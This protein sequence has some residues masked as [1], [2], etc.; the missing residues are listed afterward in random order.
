MSDFLL[1]LEEYTPTIPDAVI[2][3][4]LATSGFDTSDPRVLRLLNANGLKKILRTFLDLR[5]LR[6]VISPYFPSVVLSPIYSKVIVEIFSDE[7]L[8][9]LQAGKTNIAP[10]CCRCV[11]FCKVKVRQR[12]YW[13][14]GLT[15]D[16]ALHISHTVV[17]RQSRQIVI[18]F[19]IC[20]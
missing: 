15:Y 8:P 2:K 9:L 14:S 18:N 12:S 13:S 4:Y 5:P 3:H 10:H 6:S 17:V 1:Q 11:L 20:L 16:G 19:K 7:P